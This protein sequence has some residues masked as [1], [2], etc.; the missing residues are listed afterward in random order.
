M[1]VP[2]PFIWSCSEEAKTRGATVLL[3]TFNPAHRINCLPD[4]VIAPDTGPELLTGSTRLKAGAAAKL[5]LNIL[6]TLAMTHSGKVMSNRMIDLHPSNDKLRGQ[7]V[8]IVSE[9]TG[10]DAAA[11]ENTLGRSGWD[12]RET[13]RWLGLANDK[14]SP[15]DQKR[16]QQFNS[17]HF[18]YLLTPSSISHC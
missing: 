16:F 1:P 5:I 6:T 11:A 7:A 12:V 14:A 8:R 3:L 10:C 13:C 4:N 15:L 17:S 9:L 2:A 18:V